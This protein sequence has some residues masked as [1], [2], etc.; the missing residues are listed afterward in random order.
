ME[1][2]TTRVALSES[3]WINVLSLSKVDKKSVNEVIN[4]MLAFASEQAPF[5][6]KLEAPAAIVQ[7]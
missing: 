6:T 3:N 2:L 7:S 5:V 4:E 1:G